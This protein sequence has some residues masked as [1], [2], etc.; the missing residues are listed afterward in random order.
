MKSKFDRV[1]EAVKNACGNELNGY[2]AAEV[3]QHL[4][5]SEQAKGRHGAIDRALVRAAN[6][7]VIG[8]KFCY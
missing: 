3:A 8:G 4:L 5:K 6:P 1:F 7:Y 2:E